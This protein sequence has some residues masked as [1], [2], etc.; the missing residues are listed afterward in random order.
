MPER[1]MP[2]RPN[3]GFGGGGFGNKF[4][5]GFG[6]GT[7]GGIG[8]SNGCIT[9]TGGILHLQASGDG[10]DA[11]GS[12]TITGGDITI[13]GPNR[14]DT[15]SLDYDTTATISDATFIATGASGMAQTLSSSG[16]GIISANVGN[17]NAGTTLTLTDSKGNVLLSQTPELPY[18]LVILSSPDLKSGETYILAVSDGN[19]AGTTKTIT[20]Q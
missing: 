12:L 19:T 9:I 5:G 11:N 13:C 14:G 18:S 2:S 4:G 20:A 16:Q 8:S 6:D 15:A 17:Q 1:D 3:G 7:F 10:I